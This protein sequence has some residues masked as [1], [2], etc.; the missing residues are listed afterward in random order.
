MKTHNEDVKLKDKYIKFRV[1]FKF[2]R[3][4]ANVI[5]VQMG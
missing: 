4:I 1:F 5:E 3:I 2:R